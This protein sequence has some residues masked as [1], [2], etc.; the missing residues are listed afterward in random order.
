MTDASYHSHA[1]R[2]GRPPRTIHSQ[3]ME[4]MGKPTPP[5]PS[6]SAIAQVKREWR[7]L[8]HQIFQAASNLNNQ[9]DIH[10]FMRPLKRCVEETVR[11]YSSARHSMSTSTVPQAP[12]PP[13]DKAIDHVDD[14]YVSIRTDGG[15]TGSTSLPSTPTSSSGKGDQPAHT[16]E[17]SD[18]TGQTAHRHTASGTS[19]SRSV[20]S[21]LRD[22][23]RKLDARAETWHDKYLLSE[24]ETC[25]HDNMSVDAFLDWA[26][27]DLIVPFT[28]E[29]RTQ[30]AEF[31][32]LNV[33]NPQHISYTEFILLLSGGHT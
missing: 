14:N 4:S 13:A 2:K 6:S 1:N 10:D 29:Q 28:P 17:L 3:Q 32:N 25:G 12:P 30:L 16:R 11:P 31:M 15:S 9:A 20:Q 26:E 21:L 22:I 19:S 5:S 7:E 23:A 24:R 33:Q 27:R 8:S 18:Q